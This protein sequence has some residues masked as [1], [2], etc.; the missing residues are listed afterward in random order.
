MSYCAGLGLTGGP[1]QVGELAA[2]RAGEVLAK[3]ADAVLDVA[4]KRLE[5]DA[6]LVFT[7]VSS[8]L[9]DALM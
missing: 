3:E 9:K 7:R 6:C 4:G 5:N 8:A 1:R 2:N